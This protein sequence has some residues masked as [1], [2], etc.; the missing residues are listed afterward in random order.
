LKRAKNVCNWMLGDFARLL[1]A[2]ETDI[3]DSRIQPQ[4]LYEMTLLIEDGTISGKSAKQVFERMFESGAAPR[5]IVEELGL[6]QI[7]VSDEL[8][9]VI[10]KVLADNEKAAADFRA[11]KSEAIKYLMGQVMRETRGRA[12]PGIV[13]EM[14]R[15]KL[16]E[17]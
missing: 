1:H 12:N 4:H 3:A 13:S 7:S 16:S 15:Q 9:S 6:T 14:L 2:T 17:S 5:E 11:G 10:E 8:T